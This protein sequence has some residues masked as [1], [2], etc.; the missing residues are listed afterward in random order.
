LS[1]DR[2]EEAV[3]A[4]LVR[5]AALT[6]S[7][8]TRVTL[9]YSCRDLREYRQTF[10][11]W[12]L[13]Q[14]Y[15]VISGKADASFH[16]LHQHLGEPASIVPATPD[17]ALDESRWWLHG[18]LRAGDSARPAILSRY[19]SLCAGIEARARRT[20]PDFTEFDGH[21]PAAG[22]ALDPGRAGLVISPTQ[23][24]DAAECPFRHFLKR[25]L[26]VDAIESGE[27]DRDVWLNPL[28]RGSLLHDLYASLLRRCRAAS[29]RATVQQDSAWLRDEGA[30][31][32][33]ALVVEM[34]PPSAEVR[35]RE[36][37]LFLEDLALF[38]EAEAALAQGRTPIGFEVAFGRVGPE[39]DEPLAQAEPVTI[40]AGGLTLRIAG[41]IDRID[42][43]G[44][45]EF[46]IVDYKTGGYYAPNW[47]GTFAGGTRLQHAL[48]GLAAAELLRHHL[49][50]KA[51]VV[52]ADYYFPSAKGNQ[53]RKRIPAPPLATVGQVLSDL[54]Q[55]IASGLFVH[56]PDEESCRWCN[57]GLA[58]GRNA[59]AAAAAKHA[60]PQL[61]PFVR[62][63]SHE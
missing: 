58:C 37:T 55:V 11:S 57:H 61:A 10:A 16:D 13:L 63:A 12:I 38:V 50:P 5:L 48:Y 41:R 2:T 36:T 39:D 62:L 17:R 40:D 34:P 28:L 23:L 9:S 18:V 46:E 14:A 52:G 51:R 15:R 60:D 59:H 7:P 30:R 27:R 4:A 29:R 26:G 3:Y 19:P 24:E 47:K 35:D 25:G 54:R 42:Q 31:M 33:D 1:T 43:V 20:S 22:A 32:L 49:H 21:V 56:A 53:E 8:H 6:A 45:A 44:P